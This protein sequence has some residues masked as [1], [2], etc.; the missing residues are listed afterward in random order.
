MTFKLLFVQGVDVREQRHWWQ[1]AKDK[2]WQLEKKDEGGSGEVR[3]GKWDDF[4]P[5]L[6]ISK[7]D[8]T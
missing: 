3:I 1:M 5:L 4:A 6:N 8:S 7:D 2:R